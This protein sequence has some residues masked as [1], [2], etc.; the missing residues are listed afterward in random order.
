MTIG[1]AAAGPGAGR[2]VC[3]A[4]AAV[5]CIGRGAIGGFVSFVALT[6]SGAPLRAE[7]QAGGIGALFG[8]DL[9]DLPP[10]MAG[11][12]IAGLMSSGPNRPEPLSRFTPAKQGVGLVTGHRMPNTPGTGGR[13][14]NDDVLALMETGLSPEAAVTRVV[15]A[16]P[17][18]DAG[19]IALSAS[20]EMFLADTA[21]VGRRGDCGQALLR[22]GPGAGGACVLHNSILPDRP[23][24]QLVAGIC[25]DTM[26]PPDRADGVLALAAG[27]SVRVGPQNA[28]L[29]DAAGTVSE[30]LVQDPKFATG[31]WSL[32]LGH[33]PPVLRGGRAAGVMLYEPYLVVRD[34]RVASIDGGRD[35]VVP[36]RWL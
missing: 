5:E 31:E 2:A 6:G 36:V 26:W 16:N 7:I 10:E 32:G 21:L 13:A 14:L 12:R 24:A 23:L 18:V 30:I 8:A 33:N 17:E 4:L 34:G 35:L 9:A 25:L 1:I 11:A 27:V 28:L 15:A 22:A 29:C 3:R 19:L 20:G